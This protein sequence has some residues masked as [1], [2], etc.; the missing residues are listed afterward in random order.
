MILLLYNGII[1]YLLRANSLKY[2][3]TKLTLLINPDLHERD[4]VAS[5]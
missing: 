4:R 1:L 2:V 5:L 3:A